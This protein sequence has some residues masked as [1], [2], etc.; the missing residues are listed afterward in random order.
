MPFLGIGLHIG[1]A[2]ADAAVGPPID[3]VLRAEDGFFLITEDLN[4]I[5]FE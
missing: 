5:A 2:D 4:F 3:G 1:D